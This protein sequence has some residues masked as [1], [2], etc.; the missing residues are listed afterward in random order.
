MSARLA[1]RALALRQP[2]I[3]TA[4]RSTRSF[5]STARLAQVAEAAPKRPVGA[6]RGG[7]LGFLLGSVLAGS[8]MYYYVMEE[9]RVSNSLLTQD[10]YALQSAVQRTEAYVRTLEEKYGK[11]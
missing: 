2:A 10:I 11:K 7:L 1:S 4:F 5:Q 3:S 8:G 6:F 9:Y